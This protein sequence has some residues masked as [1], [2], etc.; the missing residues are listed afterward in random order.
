MRLTLT[1]G[2]QKVLSEKLALDET[3]IFVRE[4]NHM[5]S[6]FWVC[7]QLLIVVRLDVSQLSLV[8]L[9]RLK[10]YWLNIVLEFLHDIL[11]LQLSDIHILTLDVGIEEGALFGR[12]AFSK[13]LFP[14]QT[15]ELQIEV[16]DEQRVCE[17]YVCIASIVSG[18]QVHR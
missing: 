11:I 13:A 5:H 12:V 15:L 16:Q 3:L 6:E 2:S 4:L 1:R 17:I 10:N 8:W 14:S 7:N 9:Q 18:F